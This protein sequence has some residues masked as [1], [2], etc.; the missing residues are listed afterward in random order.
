MARVSFW[1]PR[2]GNACD[3]D[4]TVQILDLETGESIS[5]D[6]ARTMWE[7]ADGRGASLGYRI[8]P[9]TRLIGARVRIAPSEVSR[10]R[11]VTDCRKSFAFRLNL[12]TFDD[13][14][15]QSIWDFSKK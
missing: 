8:P 11:K 14:G 2:S 7:V 6:G 10:A 4:V 9:P 3:V 1:R 15:K 12:D 13:F 5:P